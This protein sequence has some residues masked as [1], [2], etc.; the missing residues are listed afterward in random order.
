V[1]R[2]NM[3]SL[4]R[5]APIGLGVAFGLS[6]AFTS[7][8]RDAPLWPVWAS[9]AV[10]LTT[11]AGA[12]FPYGLDRWA[13]LAELSKRPT[14]RVR[15]V[16][17]RVTA[18]AAVALLAIVLGSWVQLGLTSSTWRGV[19]ILTFTILGGV[20]AVG[21]MDGVRRTASNE[22]ASGAKGEQVAVLVR[23][24]QLLQR[25]LAAVGSLVALSTFATAALLA[26]QRSLP[27]GSG[28]STEL[29]PQSVL[30]F[31]GVGS[32]LVALFYVPAATAIQRRGQRLCDELFPLDEAE[33]AS[34]ILSLAEGRHKLE[35]LLGVDRGVLA[36]LQ[37]GLAILG[38]LLAS[39]AAA[40]L[41]PP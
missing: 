2:L 20:P 40:F 30:V 33:E 37:T 15:D 13:E 19:A 22:S 34:A 36:D 38:P 1:Q 16:A 35:Q 41:S 24:R 29:P 26:S 28:Q 12:I 21:V 39:A 9:F 32:L 5:L 11:T 25:L 18:I 14:V 10:A 4:A 31:G 8:L 7:S 23:L 17:T 3:A 6:L 27:A